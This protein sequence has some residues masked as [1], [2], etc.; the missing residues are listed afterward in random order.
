MSS[1]IQDVGNPSC[2]SRQGTLGSL[3]DERAIERSVAPVIRRIDPFGRIVIAVYP[4]V[5]S[6]VSQVGQCYRPA[7]RELL[8]HAQVPLLQ[9]RG[10]HIKFL[11]GHISTLRPE[12]VARRRNR[13]WVHSTLAGVDVRPTSL[14]A[15]G[16]ARRIR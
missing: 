6:F 8:L 7:L 4:V 15:I 5:S 14:T 13:E 16:R 10:L 2:A 12:N 3:C 11:A 1:G 9:V